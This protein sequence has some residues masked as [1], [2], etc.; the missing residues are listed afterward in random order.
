[1]VEILDEL[2]VVVLELLETVI[3]IEK[4]VDVAFF[5]VQ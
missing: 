4:L 1:M 5:A 2:V 3:V